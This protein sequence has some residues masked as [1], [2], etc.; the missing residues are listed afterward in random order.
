VAF[1][2]ESVQPEITPKW[3]NTHVCCTDLE[4]VARAISAK[5]KGG[6]ARRDGRMSVGD[7][8]NAREHDVAGFGRGIGQEVGVLVVAV[9]K[10]RT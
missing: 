10:Q 2:R 1:G 5:R 6:S 7:G 9:E 4:V 3:E 8:G